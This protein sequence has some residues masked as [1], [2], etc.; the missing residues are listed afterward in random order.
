MGKDG[1]RDGETAPRHPYFEFRVTEQNRVIDPSLRPPGIGRYLFQ[2]KHHRTSEGVTEARRVVV[3]EFAREI[4]TNVLSR[5]DDERVNYFFLVTN[6]PAS[7]DVL[8]RVDQVRRDL[9]VNTKALYADVWWKE[10]VTA[11][12]DSMPSVWSSFPEI[13]AGG[14]PPFLSKVAGRQPEG[15]PRAV[16]IAINRQYSQDKMVKFRQIELEKTLAKLFVDLDIDI[17]DVPPESQQEL[18]KRPYIRPEPYDSEFDEDADWGDFECDT[19]TTPV[20]DA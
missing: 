4:E 3:S 14:V 6:V 16:R 12:L 13:F 11:H 9:L 7:G 2:V 17:R 1:G 18:F 19:V 15:L 20:G 5:Q 8:E 10:R